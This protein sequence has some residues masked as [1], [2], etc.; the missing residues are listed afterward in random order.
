MQVRLTLDFADGRSASIDQAS[1]GFDALARIATFTGAAVSFVEN[2]PFPRPALSGVDV[3]LR[4]SEAPEYAAITDVWPARST[5]E[6]GDDL[7]VNARLAPYRGETRDVSRTLR[8]PAGMPPGPADLIVGD[9]AAAT[10][11]RLKAA[12]VAPADFAGQLAQLSLIEPNTTLVAALETRERGIALNGSVAAGAA[13]VV[14]RHADDRH[15]QEGRRPG[16]RRDRRRVP[17]VRALPAG[18][19]VPHPD[20]CAPPAGGA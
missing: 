6:P 3:R 20:H 12:A 14:R 16:C 4:R 10:D 17:L 5:V 18:R 8:V 19:G 1:R 7:V 2:S 9:G 13:A 15:G 11:Y